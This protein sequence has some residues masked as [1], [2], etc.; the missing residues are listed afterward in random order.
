MGGALRRALGDADL[1]RYSL[2]SSPQGRALATARCVAAVV[3]YDPARI[4]EEPRLREH[5]FGAWE[6]EIYAEVEDL[7][8]GQWQARE[9]DKWDYRVPGGESWPSVSAPGSPN[10]RR[11]RGSSSSATAWPAAC[12]AAS[13]SGRLRRRFWP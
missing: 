7:F 10:R 8:P 6:G 5:G 13:T 12:C 3:G 9:A 11:T 4:V 2:V 1:P